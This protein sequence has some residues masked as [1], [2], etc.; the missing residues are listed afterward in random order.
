MT[1]FAVAVPW[2]SSHQR[3]AAGED[4]GFRNDPLVE[5]I[6][7]DIAAAQDQA[8]PLAPDLRLVLQSGGESRG[9]GALRQIMGIG[10]E[11]SYRHADLVVGHLH[12]ARGPLAND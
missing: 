1:T 8:D 4:G 7:I 3:L 11:R 9:A 10:P 2:Q 5:Q 6:E 12:D